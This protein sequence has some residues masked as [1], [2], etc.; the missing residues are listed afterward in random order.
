MYATYKVC[1]ELVHGSR[2]VVTNL[3]LRP[4]MLN[5]FIQ[6]KYPDVN[7][8]FVERLRI[9]S[10]DEMAHFWDFRGPPTNDKPNGEDKGHGV[11]Y[12][13]DEAHIAFNA[14]DWAT[15]G[16]AAIHYMS[17]HRKLGD[18]VWP[19]TQSCGN[20]DKQFR[21]VAE[22]YTVLRNEYTAKMGVFR[23]MGRFVRK[24]YYSEPQGKAEPFETAT[25]HIDT[26]GIAACY[27]TAKGIGV[28]GSKADIGRRAKGIPIW[29]VFPAIIAV[30]MMCV[31]I[32]M[33]MGRAAGSFI[34]GGKK[35]EKQTSPTV[36]AAT[37]LI[38]G[39]AVVTS[40]SP[41]VQPQAYQVP[42]SQTQTNTPKPFVRGYLVKGGWVSVV[43]DDGSVVNE[44]DDRLTEVRRGR[45]KMDGVWWTPKAPPREAGKFSQEI[46]N[47]LA[48][49]NTENKARPLE[50]KDQTGLIQ[51]YD[52]VTKPEPQK[53]NDNEQ[54]QKVSQSNPFGTDSFGPAKFYPVRRGNTG[55]KV[56][57]DPPGVQQSR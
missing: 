15:L 10:D 7:T 54:K 55:G 44:L 57:A 50:E 18:I 27:D 23:G 14:R 11:A 3:P 43:M 19:I 40:P 4:D 1:D 33:L 20:L 45:V 35:N 49:K 42:P 38:P 6:K 32:P 25:F 24:S 16:R 41:T 39:Y 17:Q 2:N 12:F 46:Y 5:E 52:G 36:Q 56:A 53:Q 8:R 47:P 51:S 13:L 31:F 21:S 29:M 34:G 9:M 26:K 22:D 28:H 37:Q 30:A 48:Q